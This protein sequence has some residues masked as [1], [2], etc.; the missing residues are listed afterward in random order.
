MPLPT[1][2]PWA[3]SESPRPTSVP[4]GGYATE[5]RVADA[6]ERREFAAV[7][8]TVAVAFGM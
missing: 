1:M 2:R 3:R 7:T 5:R 8:V 4:D 6:V